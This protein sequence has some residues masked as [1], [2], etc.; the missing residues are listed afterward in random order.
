MKKPLTSDEYQTIYSKVPRLT[1]EVIIKT[2]KGIVLT[3]RSMTPFEGWWH[4]PGGTVYV[5]ETVEDAVRRVGLEEVGVKVKIEK[6]L[7]YL[8]YET[9]KEEGMIGKTVGLAFLCS[10]EEGELRGSEQGE[11]VEEFM[12][13]PDKTIPEQRD[14]VRKLI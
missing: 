9:V 13:I 14:F 8:D 3:L 1:V 7:G 11:K 6:F 10:I 4:I 12:E 2:K 5:N